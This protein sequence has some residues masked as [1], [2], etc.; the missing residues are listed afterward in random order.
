MKI[1]TIYIAKDGTRFADPLIC[2]DYEKNLAK[3]PGTVGCTKLE[4]KAL[5][6]D[7]YVTG[8]LKVKSEEKGLQFHHFVTVCLDHILEHYVNINDL[9]EDQ[10]WKVSTVKNILKILDQ[11][12][13]TDDCEYEFVYSDNKY[14]KKSGCTR[15]YNQA[16]WNRA[17]NENKH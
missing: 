3:I 9:S 4:L 6:E 13:E 10:R 14:F 15:S 11:Y 5:G 17:K 2:Q 12:E 16:F 7:K 1:E 8:M